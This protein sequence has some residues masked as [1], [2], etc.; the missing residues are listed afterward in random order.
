MAAALSICSAPVYDEDTC[1]SSPGKSLLIK[2]CPEC[3]KEITRCPL[4]LD[5][6]VMGSDVGMMTLA[7]RGFSEA[8]ILVP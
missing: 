4:Y 1:P 3:T 8:V 5:C 7:D 6:R 2:H